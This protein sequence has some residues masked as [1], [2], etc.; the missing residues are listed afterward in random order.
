MTFRLGPYTDWT[1]IPIQYT[2]CYIIGP[3]FGAII[4]GLFFNAQKMLYYRMP[5]AD[6]VNGSEK[7]QRRSTLRKLK[8]KRREMRRAERNVDANNGV[9][10]K[11]VTMSVSENVSKI[12][13]DKS[14]SG[15]V[16]VND[17]S[18]ADDYISDNID[19]N[20]NLKEI[21]EESNDVKDD[22]DAESEY[23]N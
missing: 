19:T 22:Y 5:I 4:A 11:S 18:L 9:D 1:H 2:S 16:D 20:R 6:D 3:I 13:T 17:I 8:Q 21:K 7:S 23:Y 10:P 14:D 15:V 12:E